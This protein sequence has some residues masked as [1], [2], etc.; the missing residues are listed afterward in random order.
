[1]SGQK[2]RISR[3]SGPSL[4][5]DCQGSCDSQEALKLSALVS[6]SLR[7][8]MNPEEQ[9]RTLQKNMDTLKKNL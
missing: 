7:T 3:I 4:Q 1:L 8:Q 2:S 6:E 9:R 5:R